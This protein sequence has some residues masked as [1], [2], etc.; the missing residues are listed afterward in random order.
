MRKPQ[1]LKELLLT[2][3]KVCRTWGIVERE[4][5]NHRIMRILV[6]VNFLPAQ[7][8]PFGSQHY[9]TFLV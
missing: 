7:G 3:L 9:K 4:G 8:D 2:R 1:P 5:I 6:G